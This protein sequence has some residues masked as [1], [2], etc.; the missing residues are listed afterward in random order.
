MF[1]PEEFCIAEALVVNRPEIT[2]PY[3]V[4]LLRE[5]RR[6]PKMSS[7]QIARLMVIGFPS[8]LH[9]R[10][11]EIRW[12]ASLSAHFRP[13]YFGGQ[14]DSRDSRKSRHTIN[15]PI[16]IGHVF[17]IFWEFHMRA[18]SILLW[19]AIVNRTYVTHEHLYMSLLLPTLFGLIYCGPP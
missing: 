2:T 3:L 15:T 17:V 11:S 14:R 16:T 4:R 19:G 5:L 6:E 7:V 10:S 12:G 9:M 13:T 8:M 18:V 1:R